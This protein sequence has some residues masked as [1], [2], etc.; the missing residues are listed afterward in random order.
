MTAFVNNTI[1]RFI[2]AC[3]FI[4]IKELR[5]L[6]GEEAALKLLNASEHSYKTE[7]QNCFR[8]LMTC[9]EENVARETQSLLKRFELAGIFL[10][11]WVFPL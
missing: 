4:E 10:F 6:I 8:Q 7:L 11:D 2:I 3:F 1:I 9:S 5:N